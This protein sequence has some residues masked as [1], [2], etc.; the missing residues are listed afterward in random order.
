MLGPLLVVQ[1][2]ITG[3]DVSIAIRVGDLFEQDGAVVVAAPTSFEIAMDDG[4]IDAKS[5]QGQYTLQFCDS[6]DNLNRQIQKA[7]EGIKFTERDVEN[8]PF[9]DRRKY[10]VGTIAPVKM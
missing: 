7:L 3:T 2:E 1:S 4:T 6:L 9:G 5:V 8:K 10:P